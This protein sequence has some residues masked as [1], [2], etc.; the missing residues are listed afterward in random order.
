MSTARAE[1]QPRY[2]YFAGTLKYTAGSL[3]ML[4]FW[5]L[6]GSFFFNMQERLLPVLMPLSLKD[7]G[8]SNPYFASW[9]PLGEVLNFHQPAYFVKLIFS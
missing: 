9:N 2:R 1:K 5:M 7:F 8:C 3:F 6:L 4:F